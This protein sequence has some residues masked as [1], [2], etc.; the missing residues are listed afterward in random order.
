[1]R[2]Y[3]KAIDQLR[4]VL[5]L[6]P[7]FHRAHYHLAWALM[8]E[9]MYESAIREMQKAIEFSSPSVDYISGLGYA[10]ALAGRTGDAVK[11][12]EELKEKKKNGFISS[13]WLS[14]VYIGLGNRGKAMEY[15]LKSVE[16]HDFPSLPIGINDPIFDDLRSDPR[17]KEIKRRMNLPQ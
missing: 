4:K 13:Y 11:I 17:F 16:S 14:Q 3:D 15:L 1:M 9:S 2:Q 5:D 10:Y 8:H 12:L 7:N 6:E